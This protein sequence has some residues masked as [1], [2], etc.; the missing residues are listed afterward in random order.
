MTCYNDLCN[1]YSAFNM[2]GCL[3][4]FNETDCIS[5][6]E[7]RIMKCCNGKCEYYSSS[8]TYHCEQSLGKD[9]C[10]NYM[11]VYT[12]EGVIG[13]EHRVSSSGKVYVN[14]LAPPIKKEESRVFRPAHYAKYTMEPMTYIML[15][16]L[17]FAEGCVIKYVMRWR[18]KNGIEDLKKA[19]RT[20]EMMIEMELN[21]DDYIADKTCL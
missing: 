5:H 8:A 2:S 15:N 9:N 10:D 19:A 14:P 6:K 11:E 1:Y 21:S 12:E 4:N 13:T 7:E 17:P 20:I 18:D 16:D 3:N